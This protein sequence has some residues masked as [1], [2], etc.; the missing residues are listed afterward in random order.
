[1][2]AKIL[3]IISIFII[4]G[5]HAYSRIGESLAECEGR[6]GKRLTDFRSIVEYGRKLGLPIS[7]Y[8]IS[9][10]GEVISE[11]DS[12][13]FFKVDNYL[14]AA[15]F[16]ANKVERINFMR[17][18]EVPL[19]SEEVAAFLSANS[20]SGSWDESEKRKRWFNPLAKRRA[21]IGL[22]GLQISS[23]EIIQRDL[24]KI[25]DRKDAENKKQAETLKKF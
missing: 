17:E 9:K 1:M 18:Y 19:S 21:H 16:V 7:L 25:Q 12:Y 10:N 4:S 13:S 5:S 6:Y 24:K 3:L 15:L 2:K 23:D 11:G 22:Y 14:I 20:G 8:D